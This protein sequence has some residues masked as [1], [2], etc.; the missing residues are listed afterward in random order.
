MIRPTGVEV[1]RER[2]RRVAVLCGYRRGLT[3]LE[4]IVVL[5]ILAALGTVMI[6]Q[7]AG[8]TGEARYEST[9]RMLDQLQDAVV[10][11]QP[12]GSEDPTAVPPGFVSDMGRLPV[13]VLDG[14]SLTLAELWDGDLFNLT[15]DLFF[16]PRTLDGLDNDLEMFSGWRGPYVRLPIGTDRLADGWGAGYQLEDG[17][18][19]G[20]TAAG[21]TIGSIRS[22]GS[23][24]TGDV[25]NPALPLE[26]VM[27]DTTQGIDR[28][29]SSMPMDSLTV[30]FTVPAA[31]TGNGVVRLYG[32]DNGEPVLLLQSDVF[33]VAGTAGDVV[34][35]A[36]VFDD[37]SS[38]GTPLGAYPTVVGPKVL[39]AYAISGATAPPTDPT[40]A[41]A[42][43]SS[44]DK[45]VPVRFSLPA[46]GLNVLPT[47]LVLEG[48]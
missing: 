19:V 6:T 10:G 45:S 8:L 28:V 44:Q 14:S 9:V 42:E 48:S 38:P 22:D 43:L 27:L 40:D 24:L 18:G 29:N 33:S 41:A 2:S 25:Y 30:D 37:P 46:G 20:V 11:R 47:P 4:L 31:G 15:D 35:V 39:R 34:T 3:L 36:V 1:Q 7:T 23:G 17:A 21:D 12:V 16:R 32:I 26:V 13:A 5:V